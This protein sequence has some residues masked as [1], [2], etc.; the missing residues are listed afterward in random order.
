ML[1]PNPTID[2]LTRARNLI[3]DPAHWRDGTSCVESR[4][5]ALQ[6]IRHVNGESTL[7]WS[8]DVPKPL[9][10]AAKEIWR[11]ERG[12]LTP[13]DDYAAVYSVNDNLGHAATLPHVR[14]RH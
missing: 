10:A 14:P 3:S 9:I 4:Y 7:H 13:Y 6:A 12:Y 8:D 1:A 5:C 2:V 11:A